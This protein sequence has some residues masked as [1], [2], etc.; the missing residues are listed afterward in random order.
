[1]E[2]WLHRVPMSC[3]TAHRLIVLQ[4]RERFQSENGTSRT[5][6]AMSS[7]RATAPDRRRQKDMN[8]QAQTTETISSVS[9]GLPLPK[10]RQQLSRKSKLQY[11]LPRSRHAA[12]G[13]TIDRI[14]GRGNPIRVEPSMQTCDS[15]SSESDDLIR[16]DARSTSFGKAHLGPNI[17]FEMDP[18]LVG[19]S[20][21]E[22]LHQDQRPNSF[23]A[24]D[25]VE[26]L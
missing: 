18:K 5:D 8:R 4:P 10:P 26:A 1:M 17:V 24:E 22:H 7:Q 11:I 3:S 13:K 21:E 16:I 23:D 19:Q 6:P 15:P 25:V 12:S 2:L 9:L 14:G 20:H